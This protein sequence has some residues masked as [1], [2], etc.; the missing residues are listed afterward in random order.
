MSLF[1]QNVLIM[2]RGTLIAQIATL[3]GG[4]YLAKLFGPENYGIYGSI[5]SL[6]SILSLGFT[7]QLDKII[8]L[9]KI[10]ES[11]KNWVS[12]IFIVIFLLS[13]FTLLV[14][15]FFELSFFSYSLDL[16]N[17]AILI[18][19]FMAIIWLFEALLTSNKSFKILS[20]SK[21]VF[22]FSMVICQFL[23][24]YFNVFNGLLLGFVIAQSMIILFYVIYHNSYYKKINFSSIK[25]E[26][27]IHKDIPYF[28]LPSNLING[29]GL[30]IMPILILAYFDV[31]SAAVYFLSLKILSMPLHLMT[32]SL[33]NVFFKR[34][35]DTASENSLYNTTKKVVVVNVAIMMIFLTLIN[36]VGVFFLEF[37]FDSKWN[38]L[39]DYLLILSFLFLA[40][41]SFNPISSLIVVKKKNNIG[42]I[43]NIFLVIINIVSIYIGYVKADIIYTLYILSVL[44]GLGYISLLYYFIKLL[45][46]NE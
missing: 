14:F 43:F 11:K 17:I 1:K 7:L 33:G 46:N 16:I 38:Q 28:L 40:R 9:S 20:N 8:V 44:G 12:F 24:F 25:N 27:N 19:S 10:E 37:I 6:S 23:L 29:I 4:L 5:I 18:A 22:S 35:S 26:V 13:F 15:H 31:N 2:L 41:A 39:N 42:L 21:V 32:S 30:H 45:K 34:A 36:T 3:I